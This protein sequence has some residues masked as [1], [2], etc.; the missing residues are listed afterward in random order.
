LDESQLS[1]ND[2]HQFKVNSDQ[3]IQEP[4][5]EITENSKKKD[6]WQFSFKDKRTKH[7]YKGRI[8]HIHSSIIKHYSIPIV[9]ELYNAKAAKALSLIPSKN[10]F[11]FIF[12]NGTVQLLMV[13]L[14]FSSN[15]EPISYTLPLR[16]HRYSIKKMVIAK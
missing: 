15:P 8:K 9:T 16:K 11:H 4:L 6:D 3:Y 7:V 1:R 13:K 14:N 10:M 12:A 5:L 2:Y